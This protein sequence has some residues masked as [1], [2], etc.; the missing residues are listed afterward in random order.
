MQKWYIN[1]QSS[2]KNIAIGFEGEL[3]KINSAFVYKK[4]T[5][6]DK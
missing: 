3:F 5:Y 2:D 6:T 1:L 4:Y